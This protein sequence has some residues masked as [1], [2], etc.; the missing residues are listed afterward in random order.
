MNALHSGSVENLK[1][2]M[3]VII[4]RLCLIFD[5][6]QGTIPVHSE[7]FHVRAYIYEMQNF[8][9]VFITYKL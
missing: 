2:L 7:K 9:S 3:F 1:V 5:K 6:Q 4:I 8:S